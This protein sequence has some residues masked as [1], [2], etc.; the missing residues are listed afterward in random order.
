[1]L[2]RVT[3]DGRGALAARFED[4]AHAD[5]G[6]HGL[7]GM[8]ERVEIYGGTVHAGPRPGGGYQV[9]VRL[10]DESAVAAA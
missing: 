4:P 9:I 5:G 7:A 6:G 10:P 1:V 3:D 8:R 2:M